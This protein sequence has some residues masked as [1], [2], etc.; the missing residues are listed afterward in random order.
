MIFFFKNMF[1]LNMLN[2]FYRRALSVNIL[3]YIFLFSI[4]LHF[5]PESFFYCKLRHG[6]FVFFFLQKALF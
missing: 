5:I 1:I 3:V 6:I 4:S 2:V